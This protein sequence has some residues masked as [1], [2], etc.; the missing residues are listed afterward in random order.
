MLSPKTGF[1]SRVL[2]WEAEDPLGSAF[3]LELYRETVVSSGLGNLTSVDTPAWRCV[4]LQADN[5][6]AAA[7]AEE[8]ATRPKVREGIGDERL[9]RMLNSLNKAL[10]QFSAVP[11]V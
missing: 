7:T 10:Y 6:T 2:L 9:V 4:G 1:T 11:S 3:H 8:L 5:I